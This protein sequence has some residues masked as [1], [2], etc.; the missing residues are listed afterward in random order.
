MAE[1]AEADARDKDKDLSETLNRMRTYESVSL[2]S[3][4]HSEEPEGPNLQNGFLSTIV[5]A[6][7]NSMS[8]TTM[9]SVAI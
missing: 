6:K 3:R 8:S 9:V 7:T 2:P 5:G 1:L 4:T